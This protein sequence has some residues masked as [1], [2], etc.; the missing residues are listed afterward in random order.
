MPEYRNARKKPVIVK[1]AQWHKHGDHPEDN[2]DEGD[3]VA[4][5]LPPKDS[6]HRTCEHC[7]E[8]MHK[9][10]L[11]KTLESGHG[12]QIVCPSDWIIKGVQGE[13]YPIKDNIFK[14][15]YEVIATDT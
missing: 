4:R 7:G 6:T 5:Y 11:V 15:T 9:H 3:V 12:G 2:G 14:E 13:F 1:V 8:Q 10:G